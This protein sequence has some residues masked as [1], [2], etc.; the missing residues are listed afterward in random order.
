MLYPE[1]N[2]KLKGRRCLAVIFER[3]VIFYIMEY[4]IYVFLKMVQTYSK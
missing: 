3:I 2:A 4:T 1:H